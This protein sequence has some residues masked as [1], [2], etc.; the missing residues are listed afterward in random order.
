M[1]VL[2]V[3]IDGEAIH[4]IIINNK[5]MPNLIPYVAKKISEIK[6]EDLKVSISGIIVN[7]EDN[8]FILDDGDNQ[9]KVTFDN[10]INFKENNYVRVFADVLY[11]DD[12]LELKLELIQDLSKI[13]KLLYKKV[14]E[15]IK[16]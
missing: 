14:Q 3:D 8:L 16:K 5:K 2:N 6:P 13:D 7:K 11:I 12:N 4:K 9:I 10:E 1:N 15:F